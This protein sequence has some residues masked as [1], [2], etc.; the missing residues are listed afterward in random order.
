LVS[1]LKNESMKNRHW[2]DILSILKMT[3][4]INEVQKVTLRQFLQ[5]GAMEA[6]DQIKEIS[7]IAAKENSFVS[8]TYDYEA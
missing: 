3:V 1:D 4:D 5:Y 8:V 7:E 2:K 6:R